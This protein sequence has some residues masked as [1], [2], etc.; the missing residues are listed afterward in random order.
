VVAPLLLTWADTEAERWP[1]GRLVEVLLLV[2][3]SSSVA[4]ILFAGWFLPRLARYP[5]EH[6]IVPFLLWAA[7]RFGPRGA[8]TMIAILSTIEYELE[9]PYQRTRRRFMRAAYKPERDAGGKVV[10]WVASMSDITERKRD[11][12]QI[13]GLNAQLQRHLEEFQALIDTAPV[14]IGIALD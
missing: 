3:S 14:G 13:H 8:A 7:F 6:L 12:A 5:L 1:L 10:G 9:V 2:V 4:A 11:E